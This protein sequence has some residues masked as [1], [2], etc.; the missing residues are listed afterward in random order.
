[1][2]KVLNVHDFIDEF[3]ALRPDDFTHQ[4]LKVLFEYLEMLEDESDD[5][6]ELDVIA[7][8]CEYAEYTESQLTN[9]YGVD[10]TFKN[11][12]EELSEDVIGWTDNTVIIRSI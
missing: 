6:M 9:D 2:K 5:Q 10:N 11:M 3:K 8:C 12:S 4:G 1:M 7:I